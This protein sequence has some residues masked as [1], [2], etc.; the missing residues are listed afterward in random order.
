[1]IEANQAV[2]ADRIER[3]VLNN[4]LAFRDV[5][6]DLFVVRPTDV[7]PVSDPTLLLADG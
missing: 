4:V 7:T 1:V 5:T 3:W 6:P 2:E